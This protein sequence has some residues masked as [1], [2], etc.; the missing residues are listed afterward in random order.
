MFVG[1]AV[2]VVVKVEQVERRVAPRRDGIDVGAVRMQ[3]GPDCLRVV[4]ADEVEGRE[5]LRAAT[6]VDECWVEG[7]EVLEDL[8]E[9][10]A[11]AC[12]GLGM[13]GVGRVGRRGDTGDLPNSFSSAARAWKT[14]SPVLVT[15]SLGLGVSSMRNLMGFIRGRTDASVDCDPS[16]ILWSPFMR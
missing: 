4:Q 13:R 16:S 3:E 1:P 10:G 9:F 5:A 12:W 14:L 2:A 6:G 11:G 15:T 7:V 8:E